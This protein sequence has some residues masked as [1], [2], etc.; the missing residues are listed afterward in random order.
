MKTILY[1]L[2]KTLVCLLLVFMVTAAKAQQPFNYTQYMDNL[3]PLN[4]AFSLT[5]AGGSINTMVRK[6]WVGV[7][8]SPSSYL[9]NADVPL[10]SINGKLGIIA[11]NDEVAIEQL[12]E[13]NAFFAKAIKLNGTTSLAVSLNA[14]FVNYVAKYSEVDASDPVFANNVYDIQPNV[15]FGVMLYSD[16]YYLGLSVPELNVRSLGTA[17]QQSNADFRSHYYF[18]AGLTTDLNDDYQIKYSGLA[19]YSSGIPV[20]ADLSAIF[21]IRHTLG[22]GFDYRTDNEIAGILSINVQQ[23]HLGYSYQVGTTSA[24]IGGIGNA[25]NEV[26]LGYRFGKK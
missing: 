3:T 6:Q 14:G 23:F 2:K 5:Q 15:G 7:P 8:G 25:T 21:N 18:S 9:L 20:V 19:A 12:T 1:N 22:L 24:N 17:S 11:S 4:P 10:E 16:K 13:V 26:T